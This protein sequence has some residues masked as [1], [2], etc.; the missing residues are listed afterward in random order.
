MVTDLSSL[1]K[2][3]REDAPLAPDKNKL[4]FQMRERRNEII[5]ALRDEGKYT[6]QI[7]GEKI[8]IVRNGEI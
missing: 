8:P 6:L 1:A 2:A 4:E 7:G 5:K 3:I